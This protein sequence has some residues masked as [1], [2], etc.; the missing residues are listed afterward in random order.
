VACLLLLLL[1]GADA[2]D[3]W[4]PPVEGRCDTLRSTTRLSILIYVILSGAKPVLSQAEGNLDCMSE[5]GLAT[6][7]FSP[8]LAVYAFGV[9]TK[10]AQ[11]QV[12]SLPHSAS[13][14]G[15]PLVAL[16]RMTL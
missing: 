2:Y 11:V 3:F 14:R 7:R 6:S 10:A 12:S 8:A 5:T 15:L 4:S 13:L 1:G 16:L 9:K